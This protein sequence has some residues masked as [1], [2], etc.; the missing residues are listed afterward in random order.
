MKGCPPL[1]PTEYRLA[2]RNLRGR[3]RWRDRALLTLGV[4]TGMRISEALS[5]RLSQL[6]DG[7]TVRPR[8]YLERKDSKGKLTGSSIIIHPKAAAA[9]MKWIESSLGPTKPDDWLFP[10][11]RCKGQPIRP[12]A[13]WYVL[14]RAF[15]AAGVS[16]MA[17]TH[18]MRKTFCQNVHRAL[19]GDLFRLA[20]AMRH[21]SPLTTLS[22]LSFRQEEIDRAILRA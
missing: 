19:G 1:S 10:S 17:G 16:G 20:K 12:A 3:W 8:V 4:R 2:L 15:L 9:L 7:K 6:H 11:Q 22:Y 18:V 5:L 13:A 14:H 21:T